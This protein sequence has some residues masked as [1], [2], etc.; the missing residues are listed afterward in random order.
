M[1]APYERHSGW[2]RR[3]ARGRLNHADASVVTEEVFLCLWRKIFRL[4]SPYNVAGFLARVTGDK[5][6]DCLRRN[7]KWCFCEPQLLARL[8]E[9]RDGGP[10]AKVKGIPSLSAELWEHLEE[11]LDPEEYE[12]FLE[13][14]FYGRTCTEIAC[15]K[16][17]KAGSVRRVLHHIKKK[18]KDSENFSERFRLFVR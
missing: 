6:C 16:G 11:R 17:L 5:V 10:A 9:Q 14:V 15:E 8:S 12:F 4:R 7:A 1:L 3:R 18:I 13:W 2:V